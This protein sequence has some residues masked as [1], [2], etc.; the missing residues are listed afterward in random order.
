MLKYVAQRATSCP[1]HANTN[2]TFVT[3]SI[4]PTRAHVKTRMGADHDAKCRHVSKTPATRVGRGSYS[5]CCT[6]RGQVRSMRRGGW[7]G[8]VNGETLLQHGSGRTDC[9]PAVLSL[10]TETCNTISSAWEQLI[11][12]DC[13]Q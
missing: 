10:L 7:K 12:Q 1:T 13:S 8:A 5:P 9:T 6:V 2:P 3:A 11:R 4:L